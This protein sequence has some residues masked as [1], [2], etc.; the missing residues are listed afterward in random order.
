M[1]TG[2]KLWSYRITRVGD[3]SRGDTIQGNKV[4]KIFNSNSKC[5]RDV[6]LEYYLVMIGCVVDLKWLSDR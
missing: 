5:L 2:V 1:S 4:F 6:Y 3:Y